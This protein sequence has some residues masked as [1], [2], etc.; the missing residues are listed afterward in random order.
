M[1]HIND[2]SQTGQ[3][4]DP[5]NSKN[6]VHT[7]NSNVVSLS[8]YRKHRAIKEQKLAKLGIGLKK[9]HI[10]PEH[11]SCE[12]SVLEQ[13]K[14]AGNKDQSVDINTDEFFIRN[15]ERHMEVSRK[16]REDRLK[17]NSQVLKTYNIKDKS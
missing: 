12:Q 4:T 15:L 11:E 10:N 1:F 7:K 9:T 13:A 5:R 3:T 14:K 2:L 16:L 8:E 6:T 17:K